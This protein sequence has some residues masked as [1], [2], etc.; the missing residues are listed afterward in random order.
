MFLSRHGSPANLVI[1]AALMTSLS[2]FVPASDPV[3]R[4]DEPEFRLLR[5]GQMLVLENQVRPV[6][7]E[8]DDSSELFE[9]LGDRGVQPVDT[10]AST[11]LE[12]LDLSTIGTSSG[13]ADWSD[14]SA[15]SLT[16]DSTS[17]VESASF[18]D[19]LEEIQG[20]SEV[21]LTE[22]PAVEII[23]GSTFNLTN[24]PDIAETLVAS[25]A[26]QT[27]K[28]R[29]RSPLGFDP[30]I[31]GF[32][33]G[34]IYATQDGA[35]QFP[36]RS[37]LDGIFSRIDQSLISN[38][39]VFSGP[40]T[41]K[42]GSGFSFL[43]VDTIPTPRY[44]C[45]WE[46]HIRLGTNIRANGGQTYNKATLFGGGESV[47]Y[48]ANVG[49]RKGSD[50]QAG[51]GLLV[52]SSYEAFNL[53]SGIGFDIDQNTRSEL[54][55]THIDQGNTEY[56]GQFFDV[57]SLTSDG[58]S[59][60]LIHRDKRSG[61][62]YR[63]DTW[64]NY[65]E[66][67]GDTAAAGK[68]RSD[69]EVLQRVDEALRNR[70]TGSSPNA[71]FAADVN[72]DLLSTGIRG[73]ITQDLDR[74]STIGLGAD[75]R[76]VRQEVQENISLDQFPIANPET[77]T[78]LPQ[79]EVIEPGLYTEY[80]FR[81]R[82]FVQ[83]AVGARIGFA[84]TQAN[85]DDVNVRSNFRL[86]GDIDEDLDVSDTLAAFFLTNDIELS[87]AWTARVGMGYAE[88][89]P[90]LEQR[91]SD[92]LF[93]A[94]IQSG[95]SRVIG[96]PSLSKERNWQVDARLDFESE[97][98]RTRFSAFHSWIVDYITYEANRILPPDGARLL[99]TVNTDLA[100]L[101]GF[102][103]Y[104]EADLDDGWQVFGSLNYLDGRDRQINQPLAGINP[105]EGRVG[106]RMTDIT[107][108]NRWGLEWGFRMVDNQDRLATLRSVA[109]AEAP[110]E[111]ETATPGF[112]T[113]YLRGYFRPTK[114]VSFTYGADN[115]FDNNYYE[116]LN[117]RLPAE[118]SFSQTVVLSPGFTPYFGVEVDY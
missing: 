9:G 44:E 16:T 18:V 7:F 81:P 42:Y 96:S 20:T 11:D 3:L 105:L 10:G 92:G 52:P 86:N 43:N 106:L 95:F 112:T 29:R 53:F 25:P 109:P 55:Y 73:G 36:V 85:P 68:R 104:T 41:V 47:G 80:S 64:A 39:Q 50:Y 115:L 74:D 94:Q 102:E 35:Y 6:Q 56:A 69:F 49:Y 61:F 38:V 108:A 37:D 32:Y 59:H 28:A 1:V 84:H 91:Y 27:V 2:G 100:T 58:L 70:V 67:N 103:Y 82:S 34:Q 76:Y 13:F 98:V 117:L 8:E 89:V 5:L 97:F 71:Q 114:N 23:S 17:L 31:R 19:S 40:Y 33:T 79:A 21:S 99:Q 75:L 60:S 22:S 77:E 78:G 62:A 113:S 66:F 93:L 88:R 63:I 72:G 30:R 15:P 54:R 116:H 107:P 83:T 87:P 14:L 51:N 24:T 111:L 101:T 48:F 45:G 65:T 118:G 90:N 110:I 12:S 26:T 46:N 57:D 4:A